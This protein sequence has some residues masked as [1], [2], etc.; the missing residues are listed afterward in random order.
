MPINQ[1]RSE[2]HC[3]RRLSPIY[4]APASCVAEI[5]DDL[6]LAKA[7]D[8]AEVRVL[9]Q[10]EQAKHTDETENH[11]AHGDLLLVRQCIPLRPCFA[12]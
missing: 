1:Q 9:Q 10:V 3:Y 2:D 7:K 5:N 12:V 8:P 11:E 6:V 4:S